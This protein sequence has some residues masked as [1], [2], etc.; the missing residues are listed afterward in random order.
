MLFAILVSL[1]FLPYHLSRNRLPWS[2]RSPCC[3]GSV[4]GVL[5]IGFV[6]GVGRGRVRRLRLMG[7]LL[8]GL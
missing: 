6:L 7:D 3:V 2:M 5:M 1:K 8:V 4:W